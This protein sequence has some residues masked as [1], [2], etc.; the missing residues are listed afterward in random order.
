[1]EFRA[2]TNLPEEELLKIGTYL[3]G[4]LASELKLQPQEVTVKVEMREDPDDSET[5]NIFYAISVKG[6]A[7]SELELFQAHR[8]FEHLMGFNDSMLN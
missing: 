5:I 8:L 4:I 1:M 2:D 3:G 7:P 6:K